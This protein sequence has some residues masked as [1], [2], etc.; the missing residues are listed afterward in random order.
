MSLLTEI[1]KRDRCRSRYGG[2]YECN[3]N[4]YY[5]GRWVLAGIALVAFFVVL[6]SC[7]LI[8]RRRRRRGTKPMY[9]TGWMAPPPKYGAHQ[10]DYQLNSNAQGY[11]N[12]SWG[13]ANYGN[14]PPSYGQTQPH[15]PQYT[16][17]TFNSNEGYYGNSQYP[18]AG[19]QS[20]PNAYQP[21]GHVYPHQK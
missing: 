14:A 17:T 19:V 2:Y 11:N 15:Q 4:W 18:N 20:P 13:G 10:N 7:C 21:E 3:S 6:L 9:G 12:Q 8:A 5:W 1:A 16:G